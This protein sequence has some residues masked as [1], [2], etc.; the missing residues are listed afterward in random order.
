MPPSQRGQG[1]AK[2]IM[3]KIEAEIV[4]KGL[5][6]AQLETGIH[7]H[8]AISL[9]KRGGYVFCKPF[10]NYATD[11]LSVFMKKKLNHNLAE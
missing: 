2:A 10:G 3:R 6:Y 4:N 5:V 11:P 1:L 9:Y 8:E 7:Q